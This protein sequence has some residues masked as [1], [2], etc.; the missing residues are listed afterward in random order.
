MPPPKYATIMK[1]KDTSFRFDQRRRLALDAK[2]LG[3]KPTARRW[4]CS[5]NTVR[6]WLRRYEAEGMAGLKERSHAPQSCPHKLSGP[7]EA[8]I[9]TL[10]N[11]TGYG[12]LRLKMEFDLPASH[13]A[14]QRVIQQAGLARKRKTNRQK[15]NDLRAVKALLRPFET[16]HMDVKFLYDIAHYLPQMRRQSLP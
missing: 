12:A 5:V 15:K 3:I 7:L 6:L 9:L 2:R 10:R 14:I 16:V 11:K 4:G 1:A 8:R 13:N